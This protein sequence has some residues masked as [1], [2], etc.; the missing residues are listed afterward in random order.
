MDKM[1][2]KQFDVLLVTLSQK[3]DALIRAQIAVNEATE[4]VMAV[5]GP[6][7]GGTHNFDGHSYSLEATIPVTHPVDDGPAF[8]KAL[9]KEVQEIIT[10]TKVE[11][12][13]SGHNQVLKME[14]LTK[15]QKAKIQ[16]VVDKFVKPKNG[17][18]QLSVRIIASDA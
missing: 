15:A 9:P 4:A 18:P 14:S 16:K 1:N 10:K 6:L 7:Q 12:S 11:Y 5:T 3:Q 17:K 13:K 2:K 8:K